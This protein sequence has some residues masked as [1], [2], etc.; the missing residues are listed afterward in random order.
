M[1]STPVRLRDASGPDAGRPPASSLPDTGDVAASLDLA[2]QL[3][4]R[5]LHPGTGNTVELLETLAT[6]AASDLGAARAVEPHLDALAILEQSGT[7]T[8]RFA[9]TSATWGVFAAEGGAGLTARQNDDAFILSGTKPWCSLADRLTAALVTATMR[10]GSRALFAVRL[11]D[12]GVRIDNHDWHARGLTEI[13]SGPVE[14]ADVPAIAIGAPGWYLERPG[15]AWGGIAVAAC[16]Y[17][18]TVGLAR[19]LFSAINSRPQPDAIALMHLGV[20]DE[21]LQSGRRALTEAARLI[22]SG[23]AVGDAGSLLAKR[24]RA[25][26]ARGAEETI[27]RVGHALG[28]A[29]LAQSAEHAKRVADLQLYIRQHHA[30][31]DDASLGAAILRQ[32]SA[33]GKGK[34]PW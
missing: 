1:T 20:I 28:P 32:S 13:P 2:V 31:K 14:F 5:G 21:L 8:S 34:A 19:S 22:D 4:L 26:I 9:G 11:G 24:V 25:T 7:S 33:Q 15:F 10:D 16:W 18:G 29:P 23:E 30:E 12:P 6:I 27:I 3:G 17:G